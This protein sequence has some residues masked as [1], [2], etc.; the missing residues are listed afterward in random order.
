M[1]ALNWRRM[2]PAATVPLIGLGAVCAYGTLFER[3]NLRDHSL[4][5]DVPG[6]PSAFDGYRIVQLS[7]FHIGGNGWAADTM[8]RAISLAMAKQG[9]LIVLSGDFV[10]STPGIAACQI[11][12][13]PCKRL[14]A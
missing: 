5:I 8:A 3:H 4:E 14:T 2:W 6:M 12:S 7:D 9:D 10:E 11:C 1:A 13:V